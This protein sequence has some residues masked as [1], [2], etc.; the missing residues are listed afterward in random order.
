MKTGK[1]FYQLRREFLAKEITQTENLITSL[2]DELK[3]LVESS[4]NLTG[5]IATQNT[6]N[7]IALKRVEIAQQKKHLFKRKKIL[8]NVEKKLEIIARSPYGS[9]F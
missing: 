1:T 6:L 5:W 4:P 3:H 9:Y 2:E 8:E 7:A